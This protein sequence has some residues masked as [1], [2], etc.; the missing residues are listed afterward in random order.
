MKEKILKMLPVFQYNVHVKS[1]GCEED[2]MMSFIPA[3]N[4]EILADEVHRMITEAMI[5]GM[6]KGFRNGVRE[7]DFKQQREL[8]KLKEGLNV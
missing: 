2:C 5:E 7:D 6:E 8:K 3:S 4:Y 1:F